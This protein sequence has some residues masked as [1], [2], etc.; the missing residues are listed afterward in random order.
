M[1]VVCS[2]FVLPSDV[3]FVLSQHGNLSK[4]NVGVLLP[5]AAF[6]PLSGGK[7]WACHAM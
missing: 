4:V 2:F 5:E 7:S 6:A 1:Y 3:G